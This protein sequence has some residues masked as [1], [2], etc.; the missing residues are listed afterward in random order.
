MAE[1]MKAL[2]RLVIPAAHIDAGISFNQA[3]I[4]NCRR[5]G[6]L[7]GA[8]QILASC[9][10]FLCTAHVEKRNKH[11][12]GGG[13]NNH[14][15]GA[16]HNWKADVGIQAAAMLPKPESPL[17]RFVDRKTVCTKQRWT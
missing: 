2:L 15:S 1:I 11:D 7:C 14:D 13:S 16:R 6:P 3:C 12:R 5:V 10:V 8:V 9:E 17:E 4:F